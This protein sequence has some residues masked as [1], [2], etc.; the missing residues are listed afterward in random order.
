MPIL[1]ILASQISGHL[2][3]PAGAYDSLAT[4][5]VPSG[6]LASITFAGIPTGYKHLQIR[7][8]IKRSGGTAADNT[9][10]T[11]NGDTGSNYV[12]HQLYGD[13]TS[14]SSSASTSQSSIRTIHSDATANVF[15]VGIIDILDY[16]AT[17]KYKTTR[18]IA[19]YDDNNTTVG[20]ALFRSGLWQNTST[21]TS[22]TLTPN[23]GTF[24]QYSSFALFG[25]K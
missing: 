23:S 8:M 14:A 6:G 15:G 21:V 22:V 3:A 5:T 2:W 11:F 10:L 16:S 12:W 25:V 19:G 7:A 24:A 17:T 4:V 18:T 9:N 20:Y 1:G 13:G